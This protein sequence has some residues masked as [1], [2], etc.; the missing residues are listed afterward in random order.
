MSE[1]PN[2]GTGQVQFSRTTFTI[3]HFLFAKAVQAEDLHGVQYF[4]SFCGKSRR[5]RSHPSTF[6]GVDLFF[7]FGK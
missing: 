3:H 6:G 5:C 2:G 7:L 1:C 4:L